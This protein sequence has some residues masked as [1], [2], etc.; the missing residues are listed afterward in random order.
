MKRKD[1]D[2]IL[3]V[4][5]CHIIFIAAEDIIRSP[6]NRDSLFQMIESNV[7]LPF[8]IER[9]TYDNNFINKLVQQPSFQLPSSNNPLSEVYVHERLQ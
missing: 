1:L 9:P 7:R 5:S 3:N 2:Y 8:P 6:Y 4:T